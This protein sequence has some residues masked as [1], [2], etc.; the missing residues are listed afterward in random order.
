MPEFDAPSLTTQDPTVTA[1]TGSTAPMYD[2]TGD[3]S[4][5]P[6]LTVGSDSSDLEA[7]AAEFATVTAEPVNLEVPLRPGYS[8]RCRTDFTGKDLDKWRKAARDKGFVDGIDGVKFSAL[9]IGATCIAILK[10]GREVLSDGRAV[11][12]ATPEFRGT[13]GTRDVDTAVRRFFA[14]EGHVDSAARRLL[15]EAG[16]GEEVYVVDPT[17]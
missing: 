4:I 17:A 7:L 6:D 16:W 14:Q 3:T 2:P 1:A 5:E 10:A 9:I 8:V 15:N 13:L 11:S 12:F